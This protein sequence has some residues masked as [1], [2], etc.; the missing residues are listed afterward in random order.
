MPSLQYVIDTICSSLTEEAIYEIIE[1]RLN[2]GPFAVENLLPSIRSKDRSLD[3]GSA[4]MLAEAALQNLAERGE[5][6]LEGE[7]IYPVE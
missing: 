7:N 5:L 3:H 4:R 6:K 1:T 2:R